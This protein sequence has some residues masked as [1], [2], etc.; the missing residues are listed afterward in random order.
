MPLHP[1][2]SAG[3]R[4]Q[5][6][7]SRRLLSV[8]SGTSVALTLLA[9]AS[10]PL[11]V[12]ATPSPIIHG[13]HHA[14]IEPT[15]LPL[16][17]RQDPASSPQDIPSPSTDPSP[18]S[19]AGVE[20]TTSR[21]FSTTRTR[22][23]RTTSTTSS[24]SPTD[25]AAAIA[26]AGDTPSTQSSSSPTSTTTTR[27]PFSTPRFQ[28]D[29]NETVLVMRANRTSVL[30]TSRG[31][32]RN[33]MAG[34]IGVYCPEQVID[35]MLRAN[36]VVLAMCNVVYFVTIFANRT[37]AVSLL[38][39]FNFFFHGVAVLSALLPKSRLVPPR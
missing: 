14:A 25:T 9:A 13:L 28:T 7:S 12:Q 29:D 27:R 16:F 39:L 15:H 31:Q 18:A 22:R 30:T 21:T 34:D 33:G 38:T 17:P 26:A 23:P 24:P 5:Q 3:P 37:S 4:R 8:L 19:D 35:I 11:G 32:C 36:A 2:S 10:A 1:C 6:G 20:S